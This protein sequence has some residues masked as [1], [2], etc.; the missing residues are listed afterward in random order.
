MSRCTTIFAEPFAQ[1]AWEWA[2]VTA[3]LDAGIVVNNPLLNT[4]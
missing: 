4:A 3:M 2:T 1:Q